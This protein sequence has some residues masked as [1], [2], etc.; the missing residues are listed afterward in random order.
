VLAQSCGLTTVAVL[1]AA[2]F[3]QRDQTLMQRLRAW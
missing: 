1:L 2:L 3:Q